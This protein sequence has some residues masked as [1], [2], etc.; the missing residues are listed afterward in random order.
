M[1]KLA[2]IG[3]GALGKILVSAV[4]KHLKEDYEL[5]GIYD[6]ILEGDHIEIGGTSLLL[7]DNFEAVLTSD[8]QIVVEIAGVGAV[9]SY[10]D[11]ILKAHKDLVI[12]SVGS[13]AD[14]GLF[15]KLKESAKQAGQKIHITSGAIGGFDIMQTLFLMGDAKAEVQST[16]SPKS[17][18]GA[19]YL[20]GKDLATDKEVIAFEGNAKEA[21]AGFPKNTNVSVAAGLVTGGAEKTQVRLISQPGKEGNTHQVTVENPQ[22]KAVIEISSKIDSKNPKSSVTAAW[23][24]AALLK[25]L[26]SPVQYF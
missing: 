21:I 11:R 9:Q 10:G 14:E 26:A 22:A 7:F 25:N 20:K 1:K 13:L 17:L 3:Y 5:I 19:P 23:S 6:R 24:V 4:L 8:A 16:K 18:N 2:I 15:A 12:T